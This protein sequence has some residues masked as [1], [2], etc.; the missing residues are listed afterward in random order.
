MV[1]K[2]LQKALRDTNDLYLDVYGNQHISEHSAAV[3]T[4]TRVAG[5]FLNILGIKYTTPEHAKCIKRIWSVDRRRQFFE[6]WMKR[7]NK[8]LKRAINVLHTSDPKHPAPNP[9]VLKQNQRAKAKR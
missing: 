7:E 5:L 3:S 1:V 4:I 6:E 9:F 8:G 2:G